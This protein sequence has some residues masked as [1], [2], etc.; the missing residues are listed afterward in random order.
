[1]DEPDLGCFMEI[2]SR[3]WSRIDAENKARASLD[4][5]RFLGASP[6]ETLQTDYIQIIQHE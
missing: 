4:L 6:D 5:L 3:T 1:M 2:K